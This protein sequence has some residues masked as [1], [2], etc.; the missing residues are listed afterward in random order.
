MMHSEYMAND[1]VITVRLPGSLK[2][3]LAERASR[4]RRSLSAQVVHELESAVARE[5]EGT[6]RKPALGLF[7]GARV[8]GEDDVAEVRA[9][10]FGRM[11]FHNG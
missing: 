6:A 2:R 4:E 8:P 5:P 10:L 11:G 1:E 7:E 9:G 3:R